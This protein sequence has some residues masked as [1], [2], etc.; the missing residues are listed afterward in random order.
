MINETMPVMTAEQ[1]ALLAELLADV[2][3]NISKCDECMQEIEKHMEVEEVVKEEEEVEDL[4]GDYQEF[5][6]DSEMSA[7][8]LAEFIAFHEADCA[9][10]EQWLREKGKL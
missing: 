3:A 2:E 9:G 4:F 6:V 1:Q 5:E 10:Y 8:D 7:E